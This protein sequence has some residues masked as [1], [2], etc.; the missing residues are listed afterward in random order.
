VLS[1]Y[2]L[3]VRIGSFWAINLARKA[4]TSLSR[5][6]WPSLRP[7]NLRTNQNSPWLSDPPCTYPYDPPYLTTNVMVPSEFPL[8][9]LAIVRKIS[10]KSS[11][12]TPIRP[13]VAFRPSQTARA[14]SL[15]LPDPSAFPFYESYCV[16]DLPGSPT[17]LP[18][19]TTRPPSLSITRL[20]F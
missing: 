3:L 16:P 13:S 2:E 15:H 14:S 7:S 10:F 17:P 6:F 11:K 4:S 12:I 8:P 5:R 9:T 20:S 1:G 18:V 19:S